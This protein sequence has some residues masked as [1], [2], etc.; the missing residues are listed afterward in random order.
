MSK[1]TSLSLTCKEKAIIFRGGGLGDFILTLPLLSHIQSSYYEVILLTKSSYFSLVNKGEGALELLDLDL[2]LS[3][4][5][6]RIEGADI[7]TFWNDVEWKNELQNLGANQIFILP[8]RPTTGPHIVEAMFKKMNAPFLPS[9]FSDTW[10]GD[11]WR[12]NSNMWIHAGSGGDYKNMPFSFYKNLADNWLKKKNSNQVTFCFGEA[13][14]KTFKNFKEANFIFS[15]RI[16]SVHPRSVEEYRNNLI[17]G[18]CEFWGNDS[19]PGHLAANLGI[20]TN[21]CF[22]ST[23]SSIWRPTGPRVNIHEFD[24]DSI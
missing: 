19:G 20:P 15:A 23:K 13:D 7:F 17:Q 16:K 10:I 5:S 12:K 24:E 2:G 8:T 21:I 4:I 14:H 6:K 18:V 1:E 22:R 3:Q 11:E 9:I